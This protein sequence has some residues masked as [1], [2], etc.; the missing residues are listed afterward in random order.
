MKAVVVIES[1]GATDQL[2]RRVAQ[3]LPGPT[4]QVPFDT[5]A[6]EW[7]ITPPADAT[8]VASTAAMMAKLLVAG[9]VKGGFSVVLHGPLG[10]SD[11]SAGQEIVRLMRA[12]RG[13]RTLHVHSGSAQS[14]LELQLDPVTMDVTSAAAAIIARIHADLAHG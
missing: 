1:S 8:A 6:T 3:Q 11:A 2:A 10:A 4:V 13:V 12:A 14:A 7:V 9:Y 5:L